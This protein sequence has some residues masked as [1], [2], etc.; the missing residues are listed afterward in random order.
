MKIEHAFF[1]FCTVHF[2]I[3]IQYKIKKYL[4][5]INILIFNLESSTCFE[6]EISSSGSR[7]YVK[8]CTCIGISSLVGRRVC[9][10]P[11]FYLQD[12]LYWC[13]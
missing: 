5:S 4:F 1:V 7:L 6:P 9:I 11:H 2:S 3:I 8:V 10:K 12:C 13:M